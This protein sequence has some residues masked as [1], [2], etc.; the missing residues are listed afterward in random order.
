MSFNVNIKRLSAVE[1]PSKQFLYNFRR[2][3][4]FYELFGDISGD[5]DLNERTSLLPGRLWGLQ[6]L[7][8][9]QETPL[10]SP[11]LARTPSLRW[12]SVAHRAW[13]LDFPGVEEP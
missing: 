2:F 3:G 12:G 4:G 6:S 10:R 8:P 9:S 7:Q 11:D 5:F 1:T 13:L